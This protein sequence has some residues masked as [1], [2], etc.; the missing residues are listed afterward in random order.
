[1]DDLLAFL[2]GIGASFI[3][4]LLVAQIIKPHI[5]LS[6]EIEMEHPVVENK[7]YIYRIKV[8]NRNWFFKVFDVSLYGKVKIRGLNKQKPNDIKSFLLKVGNGVTPYINPYHGNPENIK[9]LVVKVPFSGKTQRGQL[10]KL[11]RDNHNEYVPDY[12]GLAE[13][14]D[15]SKELDIEIEISVIC[16]H[17]FS[18]A[19]SITTKIYKKESIKEI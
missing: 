9:A 17:I 8:I 3:A 4:W 10:K 6:N 16:T 18:G 7:P 5:S 14:F 1:M 13:V 11:Y 2:L 12:F 15:I 19:R